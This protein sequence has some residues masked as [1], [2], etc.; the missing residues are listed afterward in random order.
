MTIKVSWDCPYKECGHTQEIEFTV[1]A[2]AARSIESRANVYCGKC[3]RE[4]S[5]CLDLNDNPE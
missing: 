3:H 4:Y 2:V 5:M 1:S